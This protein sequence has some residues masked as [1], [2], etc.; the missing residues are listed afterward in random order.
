MYRTRCLE[1]KVFRWSLSNR[2]ERA[3]PGEK[4]DFLFTDTPLPLTLQTAEL[5][6][7]IT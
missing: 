6:G 5:T 2:L 7:T 1:Y 4:E 3:I